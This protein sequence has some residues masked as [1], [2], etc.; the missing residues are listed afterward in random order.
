MRLRLA[1]VVGDWWEH[2]VLLL[3]R[4]FLS[5]PLPLPLLLPL[6]LSHVLVQVVVRFLS[7]ELL[8]H[9]HHLLDVAFL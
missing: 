5:L 2:Q 9:L 7:D 1:I 3:L 6:P 4:L 8:H